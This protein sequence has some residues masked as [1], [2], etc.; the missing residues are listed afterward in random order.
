MT[1][2]TFLSVEDVLCIH[3]STMEQEGGLGGIRDPGLLE[4]AVMLP[5]QRFGGRFLHED[6]PAMAAAYLYHITRNHPFTDGNKRVGVMAA[7]VFLDVNGVRLTATEKQLEKTVLAVAAGELSKA[8]LID[9][10]RK[11]TRPQRRR[12]RR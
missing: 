2:P 9:W 4:S 12:S 7:F 11:H 5:Q 8:G 1:S 3:A 10:M 6:L